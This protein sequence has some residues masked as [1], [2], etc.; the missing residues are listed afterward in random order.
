VTKRALIQSKFGNRCAYCGK[1]LDYNA[2]TLD[3]VIPKSKGGTRKE[4]NLYP[5]CQK[6]N[7]LKRDLSLDDFRK[8]IGGLFYFELKA[9]H[10]REL[11]EKIV[12]NKI[13][14][15]DAMK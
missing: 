4:S 8:M 1:E 7:G 10:E 15:R 14:E 3:H 13:K 11:L 9:R 6:C 2:V 12:I 5:A